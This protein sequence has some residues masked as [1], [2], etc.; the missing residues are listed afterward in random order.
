[1]DQFFPGKKR[2]NAPYK[3]L[4]IKLYKHINTNIN[5]NI[6]INTNMHTNT[7]ININTHINTHILNILTQVYQGFA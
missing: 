4:L 2:C 7:N 6:N 5:I 3:F 1:M